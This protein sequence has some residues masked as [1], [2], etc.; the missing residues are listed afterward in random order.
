M[1]TFTV[2]GTEELVRELARFGEQAREMA[3][4]A[5][6]EVA[7]TDV[8]TPSRELCPVD[9]GDLRGSA[10]MEGAGGRDARGRS[11]SRTGDIVV[12]VGYG[13]E[14]APYARVQH[15]R[16]DYNHTVGQA[17]Y[18]EQPLTQMAPSMPDAIARRLKARLGL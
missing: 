2:S 10:Y 9:M 1:I 11:R 14:A 13:G 18:L 17:K 15:E 7:E 5:L 3:R 8:L 6:G 16:L 4:V 12:T